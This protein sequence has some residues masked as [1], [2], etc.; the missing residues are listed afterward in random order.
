MGKLARVGKDIGV[1]DGVVVYMF[2]LLYPGTP[3]ES[4]STIVC[5]SVLGKV[6]KCILPWKL[7]N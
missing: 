2:W 1:G 6:G 5:D 3:D 4:E 7:N